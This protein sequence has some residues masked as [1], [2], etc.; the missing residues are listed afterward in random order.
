MVGT[1]I[2]NSEGPNLECLVVVREI[3][4]PR[5]SKDAIPKGKDRFT[6]PVNT[7]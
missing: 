4:T 6:T 3:L 5:S 7:E 2:V 1:F